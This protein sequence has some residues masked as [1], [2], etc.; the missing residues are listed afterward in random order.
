MHYID[1]VLVNQRPGCTSCWLIL[2]GFGALIFL[3]NSISEATISKF[4]SGWKRDYYLMSRF[5]FLAYDFLASSQQHV[6][7]QARTHGQTS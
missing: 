3:G 2:T 7:T 6:K 5:W 4:K 1:R